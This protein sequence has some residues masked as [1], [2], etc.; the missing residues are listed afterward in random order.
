MSSSKRLYPKAAAAA[1]L[2]ASARRSGSADVPSL[3]ATLVDKVGDY[4]I[5]SWAAA[6]LSEGETLS[7]AEAKVLAEK[8]PPMTLARLIDAELVAPDDEMID[9]L[10]KLRRVRLS[11]VLAE[12]EHVVRSASPKALRRLSCYPHWDPRLALLLNPATPFEAAVEALGGRTLRG[13]K[14]KGRGPSVNMLVP[15][16]L[17]VPAFF[18]AD[19]G[20]DGASVVREFFDD[21]ALPTFYIEPPFR[22]NHLKGRPV[23]LPS[24]QALLALLDS[25]WADVRAVA[26]SLLI[27]YSSPHASFPTFVDLSEV[28]PVTELAARFAEELGGWDR[29]TTVSRLDVVRQVVDALHRGFP[30]RFPRL[31]VPVVL[32]PNN[33]R[34][35]INWLLSPAPAP[36]PTE[37]LSRALSANSYLD[38]VTAANAWAASCEGAPPKAQLSELADMLIRRLG[39]MEPPPRRTRAGGPPPALVQF[40][41]LFLDD[42][43][44][45]RSLLEAYLRILPPGAHERVFSEVL[46]PV[47]ESWPVDQLADVLPPMVF[48]AKVPSRQLEEWLEGVDLGL[49]AQMMDSFEG[50]AALL[51]SVASI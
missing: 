48:L 26:L 14:M 24:P 46:A 38:L 21:P 4:Q 23:S 22:M 34:L 20:D 39:S 15:L 16:L 18:V 43:D 33:A 47:M 36:P 40:F 41:R 27:T 29:P 2:L 10:T 30:L 1:A 7:L 13:G 51:K 25:E 3:L 19:F 45:L 42:Q 50:P 44:T 17:R 28:P 35:L 6:G 11:T 37:M 12:S 8:V 31:P 32:V 5:T 9:E 49:F